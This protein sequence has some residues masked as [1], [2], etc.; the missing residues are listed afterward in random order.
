MSER[1]ELIIDNEFCRLVEN[2]GHE[3]Y[4]IDAFF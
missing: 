3:D 4:G 1:K 2:K